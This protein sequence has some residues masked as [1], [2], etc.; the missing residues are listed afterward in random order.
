[1]RI[2]DSLKRENARTISIEIVPPDRGTS[3]DYLF[4][5][6]ERLMRFEPD[7]INVTTH[8]PFTA[9]EEHEGGIIKVQQNKRPG[10]VAVCAAIREKFGVETIPHLICGGTNRFDTEDRLIEL[11]YLGFDNIFAV[12]GDPAGG[13]RRFS[14][15]RDGHRYAAGLVRQIDALKKGVYA[16]GNTSG[17]TSDFCIGVAGYPEKH[18]ESLNMEEDLIHL[19]EKIDAGAEFIITQ[20]L[21]DPDIYHSFL[22]RLREAGI[23][24]PVIPGVKP[25]TSLSAL[26]RLPGAFHL[27]V[28]AKLVSLLSGARTAEEE[29]DA[30]L[31]YTAEMIE[32]LYE[33]GAPCVHI[34]TMGEG[35]N[36][37]RL[38][39]RLYSGE[40]NWHGHT[41]IT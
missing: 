16:A 13:E 31:N 37:A 18:Y 12:R 33:S 23:T 22:Q 4:R 20:M 24:V 14:P 21:F 34:F 10:T 32:R 36:T 41:D 25:V 9:Y 6:V 28:P 15:V 11:K 40:R 1:M 39:E 2:D 17:E 27:D 8:Q 30:G 19:K 5:H 38:L 35:R 29:R 26:M 7:F 3:I